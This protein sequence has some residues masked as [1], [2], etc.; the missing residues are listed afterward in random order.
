MGKGQEVLDRRVYG[1]GE[2]IFKEGEVG[3]RC[4]YLV[5][6]GKVEISKTSGQGEVTIL[7]HITEGGIFGEMALIDNHTRMAMA[8]ALEPTAVVIITEAV[9]E[10][11]LRKADPFI[12]ALLN[13]FVRNIRETT[14]RLVNRP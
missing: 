10:D 9:F 5:Q 4:A 13:I 12:R 1:A 7:G 11:K 2:V 8:R 3:R 6:S 14:Q